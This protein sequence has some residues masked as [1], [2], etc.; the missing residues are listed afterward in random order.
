MSKDGSYGADK[1]MMADIT[2]HIDKDHGETFG[3]LKSRLRKYKPEDVKKAL[4]IMAKNGVAV[5]KQ[6]TH[7]RNGKTVERWH[8]VG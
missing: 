2:K 7:P 1:Q 6:T 3:V 8:F 4:D 5:M